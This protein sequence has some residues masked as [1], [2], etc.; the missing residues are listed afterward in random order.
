MEL[1]T[2]Q[3]WIISLVIAVVVVL[4]V[5]IVLEFIVRAARQ[6]NELVHQIWTGGKR[7][8]QNTVTLALLRDTNDLAGK[9][10]GATSEIA[11]TCSRIRQ[12]TSEL[13]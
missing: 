4:V 2:Q 1:S 13:S 9:I 5:A 3:L 8:A 6:I 11:K 12:R 7:I 10:L